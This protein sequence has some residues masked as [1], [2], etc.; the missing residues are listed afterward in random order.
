MPAKI[1]TVPESPRAGW[2][3]TFCDPQRPVRFIAAKYAN[4]HARYPG[5]LVFTDDAG[6]ADA[7]ERV[8][9]LI[10]C[11]EVFSVDRVD[12]AVQ[13]PAYGTEGQTGEW[14]CGC[15]AG[16]GTQVTCGPAA[17]ESSEPLTAG[18]DGTA[19][20]NLTV[21]VNVHTPAGDVAAA[22]SGIVSE[23]A[24]RAHWSPR[25]GTRHLEDL[26]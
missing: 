14:P 9:T 16:T 6:D 2:E 17:A 5:M 15:P 18:C 1:I 26:A 12:P 13:D 11:S 7:A 4:T 20:V 23:A 8:V 24:R 25:G 3:V 21:I 10:A 22:V 19:P